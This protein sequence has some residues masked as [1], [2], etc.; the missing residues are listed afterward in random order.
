MWSET[1]SFISLIIKLWN[2]LNVKT[3]VK[4]K[5]K[6]DYTQDPVRSS[7]DWKLCFLREFADFLERWELSE[8][9]GLSRET[10]LAVKQTCL[11]LSDCASYL[12]DRLGFNYV[13]LGNLQSDAI[14]SRFGWFRQLSGANYYISMRQVLESDR[15]IRAISLLKFSKVNLSDIEVANNPETSIV[16]IVDSDDKVVD[17]IAKAIRNQNNLSASDA[18]II[19]YVSGYIARSIFRSMKCDNCREVVTDSEELA[20]ISLDETLDYSASS[21]LDM[22]N[23][24][25]LSRPSDF[26]F[27][28]CVQCWHVFEAVRSSPDLLKTFLTATDHRN[29]FC[30]IVNRIV[31]GDMLELGAICVKNH[32]LKQLVT[33]R[34]FNCVAKN[35][36]KDLTR[37]ADARNE[38]TLHSAKKRKIAK[39]TSSVRTQ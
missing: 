31:C 36:V 17:T 9:P 10:F 32:D 30:N 29:V 1:A 35:L 38:P 23:R 25:G 6:R 3:C 19:Y 33:Q 14:E 15:K 37:S 28:L 20:P 18:N 26:T 39:L 16:N 24:G 7:S 4:G 34:F 13:L 2:V 12:I 22:I 5:H 8:K 21:F 27:S 11:A